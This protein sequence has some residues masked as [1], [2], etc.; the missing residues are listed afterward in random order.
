LFSSEHYFAR[1]ALWNSFTNTQYEQAGL[2]ETREYRNYN[3]TYCGN[4]SLC[5]SWEFFRNC[6]RSWRPE[7]ML[8]H[9][10]HKWLS[11]APW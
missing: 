3:S 6:T 8:R 7:E 1:H 11:I 10:R 9:I 2:K 5:A 4:I